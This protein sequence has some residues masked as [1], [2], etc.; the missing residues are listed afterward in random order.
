M[1]PNIVYILADDMGY[2]D[3]RHLNRDCKFPTPHIDRLGQ[4]GM[5]FTDAHSSSSLC[6]PSRYSIMTGRYCWRTYLKSGVLW[7]TGGPIIDKDRPTVASMLKAAGY[8]TACIGKW[9]L[10][11]DWAVKPGF[12]NRVDLNTTSGENGKMDWIDFSRPIQNGPTTRGFDYYYGIIASLDMPPYVYVENDTPITEPLQWQEQDGMC[13]PGLRTESLRWD[14]VL[15]NLTERAVAY[16]EEQSADQPF[17]LYFPITAPHTPIAPTGEF[18][19]KSGM[20]DYTD[21]CMEVDHRVGQVMDAI[22]R[23]GLAENTIMIFTTDN[24]S[25]AKHADCPRLQDEFGHYCSYIY[26]GFKSDIWDGGHRLPFLLRWPGTV[27]AGNV[28]NQRVGLFDLFATVAEITGQG[29][30]ESAG[31]DSISLLP[32]LKGGIIDESHREALVHHSENGM[33]AL[34]R[35]KWKLCRCPGSGGRG[36]SDIDDKKAREMGLPEIQ[37]YDMSSDP[38]EKEN[39]WEKHPDVVKELTQLLHRIVVQGRSTPG[40]PRGNSPDRAVE[41]WEQI[42]WLP[43]LPEEFL[44]SD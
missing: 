24:G 22:D 27:K 38:G 9:H 37:L 19:G 6:T 7:G 41:D 25:S 33:F 12:E 4:E 31:E 11:W 18:R 32:A 30:P 20:N 44:L 28:C 26:R 10:G 21:F 36:F 15:P 39:L 29:I 35:G 23:K 1:K 2:G 5:V 40:E 8:S 16:I 42:N 17:F 34:R 14:N 43:E 13:R 3:V